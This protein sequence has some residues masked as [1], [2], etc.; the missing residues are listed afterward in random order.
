M[1]KIL[2][3]LSI[4]LITI[5]ILSG[6]SSI[7]TNAKTT[8]TATTVDELRSLNDPGWNEFLKNINSNSTNVQKGETYV[9]VY[10]SPTENIID[11]K[12]YTK[13]EFLL[14][15]AKTNIQTTASVPVTN[16]LKFN[17]EIYSIYNGFSSVIASYQWLSKPA[18]QLE[19]IFTVSTDSTCV[20]PGSNDYVNASYWPNYSYPNI[21]GS[22]GNHSAPSKFKFAV[23]GVSFINKLSVA[24]GTQLYTNIYNTFGVRTNS[25][26]FYDAPSGSFL[27]KGCPKGV[28][29]MTMTSPTT[30]PN[31]G[32]LLFTY[33]HRQVTVNFNPSISIS[34]TGSVSIGGFTGGLGYDSASTSIRY[35]WGSTLS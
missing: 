11:E 13:S 25:Y 7:N 34:S 5:L 2:K 27:T 18:Y 29:G 17:Y 21:V 30:N 1:K 33:N 19:D 23:N 22:Y 20:L 14:E 16:W 8:K 10:E 3:C 9:K 12:T 31:T 15:Q 26:F 4:T 6:F 24:P 35:T 32:K 28:L